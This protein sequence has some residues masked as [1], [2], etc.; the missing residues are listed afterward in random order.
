[1]SDILILTPFFSP[2]IGGV[3]THLDDLVSVLKQKSF[4]TYVLTYQP[5]MSKVKAPAIQTIGNVEIHRV[6]WFRHL[7]YLVEPYPILDFLYLT[8]RLFIAT[9]FFLLHHRN[10]NI[11]HAQGINASLIAVLLKP[12]FKNRVIVSTHALYEFNSDTLFTKITRWVFNHSDKI[13]SLLTSSKNELI[14]A[15]IKENIIQPYT[16]WVDQNIFRPQDK[17]Q[18][19][20]KL[21]WELNTIHILF[22]G[23]LIGKKGVIE[24]LES[25]KLFYSESN[26]IFHLIGTGDLNELVIQKSKQLKNLNFIGKISNKLLPLYYQAADFLIVPSTHEEGAGRV[27]MEALSCGTPVIG[28]NRGGIPEI[29][30]PSISELIDVTPQNIKSAIQK[31][32]ERLSHNQLTS[33]H[34]VS[35]AQ[36]KFSIKNADTILNTY[37][38]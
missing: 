14:K 27:I 16:Y 2:N 26:V 17:V 28:S 23:R 22:V 31:S 18:S 19:K 1:M 33:N 10:I 34:C 8:P 15:G 32:I 30:D 38:E 36:Q 29:L 21:K 25:I 4:Q 7:F 37:Y 6:N 11:I 24:L 12:V 13:L 9:F 35:Y 5:L 3:E 20:N